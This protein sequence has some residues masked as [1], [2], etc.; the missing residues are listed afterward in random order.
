MLIT[1]YCVLGLGCATRVFLG[2][3]WRILGCCD[4]F[5][6]QPVLPWGTCRAKK[7]LDQDD[8]NQLVTFVAL[9]RLHIISPRVAVKWQK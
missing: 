4:V 5:L 7:I 6:P 9:Q 1:G 2:N 3:V 8:W